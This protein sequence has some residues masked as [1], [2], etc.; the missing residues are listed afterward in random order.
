[1][2]LMG[3]ALHPC[4]RW[5]LWKKH[6]RE[7]WR[8]EDMLEMLLML[9]MMMIMLL[10]LRM[11]IILWRHHHQSLRSKMLI[12]CL[13]LVQGDGVWVE[14]LGWKLRILIAVEPFFD[15]LIDR[16]ALYQWKSI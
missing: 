10:M 2:V 7:P 4:T 12:L 15:T 9:L 11:M 3:M 13:H 1:M 14:T 16:P 5:A 8:S 6:L